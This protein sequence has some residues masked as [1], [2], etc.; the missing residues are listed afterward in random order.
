MGKIGSGMLQQMFRNL[1]E[2]APLIHNIT[3]YVTVNDVA[4]LL[5]ASGSSPI[6]ADDSMEVEEITSLCSGLHLN[7]GTLNRRTVE[8]MFLAGKRANELGHPVLLDPVG[9]GAS[10]LDRKSTHLNSSHVA[11]S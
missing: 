9:A 8:S 1:K 11:I 2:R 10:K 5:L 7:I 6:M 4:N 3:N